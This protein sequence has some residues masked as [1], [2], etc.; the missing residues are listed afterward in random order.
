MPTKKTNIRWIYGLTLVMLIPALLI[1]LGLMPFIDDEA[2]RAL[3]ALEM[4]LSGNYI[5]P[6][7]NGEYYYNKPPLFNWLLLLY[8]KLFSEYSEFASRF[9]TVISLLGYGATV[10]YFF[11]KH[12][13]TKVAFI[14][15]LLLITCGRILFFDSMLG[16]IDITFSWVT[17]VAFMWVYHFYEKEKWY[18]L[19]VGTYVL[20]AAGFLMKGL[21]SVVFQG[22]TLLTFLIYKKD[23]HHLMLFLS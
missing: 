5:V 22:F 3:V 13:D 15:A 18:A 17:F 2:I 14:N 12:F 11:K 4:D 23:S 10:F 9:A 8:F 19:F 21:P 6:T 16:L 7:M 20:T 1:N